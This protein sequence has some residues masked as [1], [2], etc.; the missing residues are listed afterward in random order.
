MSG[1]AARILNTEEAMKLQPVNKLPTVAFRALENIG[2][3][4]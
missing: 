3:G 4:S 1:E 2:T